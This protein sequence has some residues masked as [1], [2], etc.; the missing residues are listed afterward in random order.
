MNK[1]KALP[2]LMCII[3][4]TF[5]CANVRAQESRF[6]FAKYTD[7]QGDTLNYRIVYPDY[8]TMRKYPLV[9]FL[10]GSGERGDDECDFK[11]RWTSRLY[12][13]SGRGAFLLAGSL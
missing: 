3:C 7:G 6:G 13:L 1:W 2:S 9:I 4:A 5:F 8:D 12:R 10:H 11:S